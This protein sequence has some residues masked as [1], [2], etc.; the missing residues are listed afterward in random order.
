MEQDSSWHSKQRACAV[1]WT[2]SFGRQEGSIFSSP[3]HLNEYT[4]GGIYVSLGVN[5]FAW[6]ALTVA[7]ME[8]ASLAYKVARSHLF[9]ENI[10]IFLTAAYLCLRL[11][12]D[13]TQDGV[14]LTDHH[15]GSCWTS[16]SILSPQRTSSTNSVS[17]SKIPCDGT[18]LNSYKHSPERRSCWVVESNNLRTL[19]SGCAAGGHLRWPSWLL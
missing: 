8:A 17:P 6:A 11:S 14:G 18:G 16:S 19:S 10:L 5:S 12:L 15:G 7:V 3:N 9:V 2:A 4:S 13:S 1:V